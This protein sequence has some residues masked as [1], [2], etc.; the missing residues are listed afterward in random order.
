MVVTYEHLVRQVTLR[1]GNE[2][3]IEFLASPVYREAMGHQVL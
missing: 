3:E 1:H 2:V